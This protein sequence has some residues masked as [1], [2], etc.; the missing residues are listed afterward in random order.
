MSNRWASRWARPLHLVLVVYVTVTPAA[1]VQLENSSADDSKR[2][3]TKCCCRGPKPELCRPLRDEQLTEASDG[4]LFAK[5]MKCPASLGYDSPEAWGLQAAD[6][7]PPP[8]CV[9]ETEAAIEA[10]DRSA[11]PVVT[12]RAYWMRHGWSCANALSEQSNVNFTG[13]DFEGSWWPYAESKRFALYRDPSLSDV[14]VDRAQK[15]GEQVRG[16]LL[17]E[18]AGQRPLVFSSVM[19]RA[20]ETAMY[21]FPGWDVH[22]VPFIAENGY[23][24]DNTPLSWQEQESSKLDRQPN[25]REALG[26][27][28][29]DVAPETHRDRAS[30]K[31]SSYDQFK[32]FLPGALQ[33][34][35]PASPANGAEIPVV[36]V[37]HS[38]YMKKNLECGK[39]SGK[40]P[41]NNEVW[42]QEYTFRWGAW[43][44]R[45]HQGAGCGRPFAPELFPPPP[46]RLCPQDVGR[47]CPESG[48]Y[49]P[50]AWLKRDA[51]FCATVEGESIVQRDARDGLSYT[52]ARQTL[53]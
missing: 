11:G 1:R 25:T 16:K 47:C 38:G 30:R 3:E 46:S 24:L 37:G 35:L 9:D 53:S 26:A 21:N 27:L 34:L 15:L 42:V 14:G 19:T 4:W 6:A 10:L 52:Q 39:E 20:M 18:T 17:H 49:R 48:T 22:P 41:A 40:K 28:K 36:I 44:A 7:A 51:E 31:K 13:T 8:R 45:L 33:E 29:F 5:K 32:N 12:V 50:K 23:S 43:D 2:S